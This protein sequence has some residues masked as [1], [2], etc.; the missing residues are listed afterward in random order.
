MACIMC[1][2]VKFMTVFHMETK[3]PVKVCASC[4]IDESYGLSL[5]ADCGCVNQDE[6]VACIVTN[7]KTREE[8]IICDCCIDNLDPEIWME[9]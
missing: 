1:G 5:C 9:G 8:K 6:T 4:P 3:F 2:N 7:I